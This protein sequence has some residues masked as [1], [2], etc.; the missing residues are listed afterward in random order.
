[1]HGIAEISGLN[2]CENLFTAA[3][4]EEMEVVGKPLLTVVWMGCCKTVTFSTTVFLLFKK[5]ME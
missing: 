3:S 2:Y 5:K 1:M 4:F